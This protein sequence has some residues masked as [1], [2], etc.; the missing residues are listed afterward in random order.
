MQGKSIE[1]CARRRKEASQR[2][3]DALKLWLERSPK[4]AADGHALAKAIDDLLRRRAA[5]A[6]YRTNGFYPID[7]NAVENAIRRIA[8]GKKNW[9]FAGSQAAGQRAAGKRPADPPCQP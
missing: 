4:F 8:L 9:F 1:E 3:L 7:N 5:V 6:C 2:R